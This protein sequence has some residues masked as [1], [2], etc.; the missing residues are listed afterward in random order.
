MNARI[1]LTALGVTTL[2]ALSGCSSSCGRGEPPATATPSP[3]PTAAGA[4]AADA[5][6]TVLMDS[7]VLG[8]SLSAEGSV[9]APGTSFGQGEPLFVSL[10]VSAISPGTDVKLSWYGP[11]GSGEGDDQLVVP[12][13]ASVVNFRAKDTSAWPPGPHRVEVWVG[14]AKAGEKTFTITASGSP[15]AP[16]SP[17]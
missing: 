12:P 3:S 6:R 8:H 14:G 17:R 2:V 9:S 16:A 13:G 5:A 11:T 15:A 7:V 1:A 4:G 10:K